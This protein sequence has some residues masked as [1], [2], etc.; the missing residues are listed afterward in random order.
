[1]RKLLVAFALLTA[2]AVGAASKTWTV[3]KITGNDAAAAADNT[4]ATPF[5]HLQA[6]I[7]NA[8]TKAGDTI[9]V[10]PGVYGEEEGVY[11]DTDGRSRICVTKQL[12]IKASDPTQE[13][14]VVGRFD[15]DPSKMGPDAVR[16][17][18]ISVKG[19]VIVGLTLRNGATQTEKSGGLNRSGAI[20]TTGMNA[21]KT[22]NYL[23]NCTISNCVSSACGAVYYCTMIGCRVSGCSSP[24]AESARQG[25]LAYFTLFDNNA[26]D[27]SSTSTYQDTINCTFYNN[28]APKGNDVKANAAECLYNTLFSSTK[29]CNSSELAKLT[30]SNLVV[31]TDGESMVDPANGDFR[32]RGG[33]VAYRQGNAE[34]LDSMV[35]PSGMTL[36]D[37]R[38]PFG[39]AIDPA[40]LHA[41]AVQ[42]VVP[43]VRIEDTSDELQ[44]EGGVVG[45]NALAPDA[46]L[47]VS[48]KPDATRPC[49]GLTVNGA[50]VSFDDMPNRK[51]VVTAAD[52]TAAG[53]IKI[54]PVYTTDWYM[55]VDGSDAN[56]GFTPGAAK[57]T[58]ANMMA[59]VASGDTVHLA[60]G[61]YADNAGT[62][63]MTAGIIRARVVVP[64]GVTLAGA[65]RDLTFIEGKSSGATA[66]QDGCGPDAMTCV[67]LNG[68][69]SCI[70]NC[71][72]RGGYSQLEGDSKTW[73]NYAQDMGGGIAGA[74]ANNTTEL[75]EDCTITGCVAARASGAQN[76]TLVRC[77]LTGNRALENAVAYQVYATGTAFL[78]NTAV[79]NMVLMPYALDSCTIA[80]NV[81]TTAT[82]LDL[83][84]T[85]KK[86][87][88]FRNLLVDGNSGVHESAVDVMV[89]DSV[90]ATDGK[91]TSQFI[92]PGRTDGTCIYTTR[93]NI[94]TDA[95]G[96]PVIGRNAGIGMANESHYDFDS[97]GAYDL[98]GAPRVMNGAMDIGAL[99]AD[100]RP[101]YQKAIGMKRGAV[102][103][104]TR[105]VMLADDEK[106]SL[107]DGDALSANWIHKTDGTCTVLVTIDGSGT[108]TVRRNGEVLGTVTGPVTAQEVSFE[109][110]AGEDA[111]DRLEVSFAGV[112]S[113]SFAVRDA[114]AG[115]MLIFR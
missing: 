110:T 96:R 11:V 9:L 36:S 55:A 37:I 47:A 21:A 7:T 43:Y 28:S 44:V 109:G 13:T 18:K 26:A 111:A 34:L 90:L 58:F 22:G 8:N 65:G 25:G 52:L 93:A 62:E 45:W 29:G 66:V 83:W 78:S 100:Y 82:A 104:V 86:N 20:Y 35:L 87:S 3:D 59:C 108:M 60:A 113:A 89:T 71:T 85:T 2:G 53:G 112:G 103:D 24:S 19:T 68:K 12:T 64:A 63:A 92:A 67:F 41:G 5:L 23:I 15:A 32:V 72:M 115:L 101:L 49:T 81:M 10:G 48:V 106:I 16:C 76:V 102:I 95:N 80:S 70:R 107:S 4:G 69:N 73:K 6:A 97:L 99:E 33:G 114:A 61:V 56:S 40:N 17:L 50:F 46:Q 94:V 57:K 105:N 1:M 77:L 38:D 74:T 98:T 75:V 54:A 14:A 30:V 84:I 91:G 79:N 27:A 51:Y 88:F 39:N 31:E 42:G